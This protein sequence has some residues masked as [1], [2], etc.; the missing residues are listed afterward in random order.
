[1][2]TRLKP[3]ADLPAW[4]VIIRCIHTRG[5]DQQLALA[6]LDRR[7]LW[8]SDEQREQAGLPPK[9]ALRA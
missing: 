2:A 5:E 9:P 1:M 8:L 6:E 3:V 4:A 7:R